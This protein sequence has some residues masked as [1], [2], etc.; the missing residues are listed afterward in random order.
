MICKSD[1]IFAKYR[2]SKSV[3]VHVK[4]TIPTAI[5]ILAIALPA[6]AATINVATADDLATIAESAQDGDV[7]VLS[8]DTYM[9]TREFTVAHAVTIRGA[10]IDQTIIKQTGSN[11]RVL[12]LDNENARVEGCTLTGG[13]FTSERGRLENAGGCGVLIKSNGGILLH[14]RITGNVS[15]CNHNRGL[16]LE[17]RASKAVVSHCIIDDNTVTGGSNGCYGGAYLLG[18]TYNHC[19]FYGNIGHNGGGVC[20]GG[21]IVMDCCTIAGNTVKNSANG[22]GGLYLLSCGSSVVSNSVVA[23][24]SCLATDTSAGKPEWGGNSACTFVN[25]AFPEGVTLSTSY[26]KGTPLSATPLFA[27]APNNDYRQRPASPTRDLGFYTPYDYQTL[28][29]DFTLSQSEIF[30][31]DTAVLLTSF[32]VGGGGA[33]TSYTWTVTAPDGTTTTLTGDSPSFTPSKIGFHDIALSVAVDGVGTAEISNQACL[34]ASSRR[35][36]VSSSAGLTSALGIAIDGSTISCAAG[37]YPLTDQLAIDKGVSVIGP[38]YAD[39]TLRQTTSNKR[40]VYM[41]HAHALVKGF[42]IT[43]ARITSEGIHGCGVHIALGGGTLSECRVTDNQ[44]KCNWTYGMGVYVISA[45]GLV[46]RCVIDHNNKTG[47]SHNG[48]NGQYGGGVYASNGIID[49]CLIHDNGPAQH[50]GGA[51]IDGP[52]ELRNC[53]IVRNT[54]YGTAGNAYWSKNTAV[55]RN[56]LFALAT[57][58][59]SDATVGAPEWACNNIK[60][61]LTSCLFPAGTAT[62]ANTGGN[63]VLGDA[64]FADPATDD[65]HQLAASASRDQGTDYTGL[66]VIDLDGAQRVQNDAV[67]IGCYEFNATS[68]T[69]SF[70][71]GGSALIGTEVYFA[72]TVTG[73]ADGTALSYAWTFSNHDGTS[74]TYDTENVAFPSSRAGWYDV[75]LEVTPAGGQTISYSVLSAL[76][77]CP[78]QMHVVPPTADAATAS[79]FP[80]DGWGNAAT[81]VQDAVDLAIDGVTILL[82]EGDHL[83]RQQLD[84]TKDVDIIGQGIDISRVRQTVNRER[85]LRLNAAGARLSRLTLCGFHADGEPGVFENGRMVSSYFS[86][87]LVLEGLGGTIED[88][89][90]TDNRYTAASVNQAYGVGI[91]ITA[92][93][94][95]VRRCLIDRNAGTS[96]QYGNEGAI[97]ATAGLVEDCVVCFN[98]NYNGAGISL[99]AGTSTGVTVR[100]C[101]VFGN[102]A[103]HSGGGLHLAIGSSRTIV[104][105]TIFFG[106]SAPSGSGDSMEW[107][108]GGSGILTFQNNLLPAGFSAPSAATGTVFGDPLLRNPAAYD[109]SIRL[110]SP[111]RDAGDNLDYGSAHTDFIGQPRRFGKFV[112]IGAV[113]CQSLPATMLLLL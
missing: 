48:T 94:G 100:N 38:G 104:E 33:T 27:D 66:S 45:N 39:A 74:W 85:V 46:S 6:V 29:C 73:V 75:S 8:A 84:I 68:A 34:L 55:F 16:G 60:A 50:G 110:A 40:V 9:L 62:N 3:E 35:F 113:E 1:K 18:G 77:V 36:E 98:T 30:T 76:Y 23:G 24:N 20:I 96:S 83:L 15:T 95:V 4:H 22:A 51:Y 58:G 41:N 67:D 89:R 37:D 112:D 5:A 2:L 19:L 71:G 101:T 107:I 64:V 47:T 90:I 25:T 70:S 26:I 59:A 69:C 53:T 56:C 11:Q 43:G 17:V 108:L 21:T 42:T 12:A 109:F 72:P 111:C 105:N 82:S 102:V 10:G 88:C 63:C 106:N 52:A 93:S 31:N 91:K 97:Y 81:N 99:A 61:T 57:S 92:A 13:K 7:L 54:S 87:G 44:H 14:C 103:T 79:A 32:V 80:Y 65:F 49:N 28:Q 86:A 78:R